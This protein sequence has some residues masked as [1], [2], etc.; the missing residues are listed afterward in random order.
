M[1]E[2]NIEGNEE[3]MKNKD[4]KYSLIFTLI[5]LIAGIFVGV[6]QVSTATEELKL[7]IIAQLGSTNMLIVVSIIQATLYALISAFVG[8]KLARKVNL[9]LNFKF[10]KNSAILATVI[11]LLAA[12][13]ISGSDKFIFAE[14]LPK[15][16]EAYNF[17]PL[18]FIVSLLY[19]GVVE[20]LMLRLF[21][22]SLICL[23][24]WKLFARS[25]DY[26]AIPS[27]IY[28]SAIFLSAILFAAGHVPATAQLIGISTPILIRCFLLN[29]FAGIGFGYLY[30]KKGFFYAMC[31]H[32]LAHIFNQIIFMP[33]FF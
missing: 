24:L 3:I 19:G 4:I 1:K 8:L 2:F 18:Y 21:L 7:Q 28:I 32:M 9:K 17:S 5:G 33:M 6:Y 27:W 13:I 10:D 12:I 16:T 29:G 23:V 22:M 20:E 14:Y 31:A 11:G 30:W 15:Q 25:K 26:S